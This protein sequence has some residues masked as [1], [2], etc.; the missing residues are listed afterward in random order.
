MGFRWDAVRLPLRC[1]EIPPRACPE[2][3]RRG[4]DDMGL[5][6]DTLPLHCILARS[7]P[8]HALSFAEGVRMTGVFNVTW[9][10]T[11]ASIVRPSSFVRRRASFVLRPSAIRHP[12]RDRV[13]PTRAQYAA[14]GQVL[15][16]GEVG[17]QT[18]W[19]SVTSRPLIGVQ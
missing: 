17:W 14:T 10:G 7:L 3:R 11:A 6:C 16:C 2:L 19:P 8:E 1:S 18:F 15:Q 12:Q 5:R 9:R 4:H 13:T